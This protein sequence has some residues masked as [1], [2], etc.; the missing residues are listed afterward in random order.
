MHTQKNSQPL[1][2]NTAARQEGDIRTRP[3]A[4]L[5]GAFGTC[6]SSRGIAEH[7]ENG[8]AVARREEL[9]S[10]SPEFSHEE[11]QSRS[12]RCKVRTWRRAPSTKIILK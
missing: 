10:N 9:Q 1:Q 7:R 12:F 2:K 11:R 5:S 3:K 8:F 4:L 6:R